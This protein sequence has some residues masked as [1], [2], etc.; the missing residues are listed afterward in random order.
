[1]SVV[2]LHAAWDVFWSS[3]KT[4]PLSTASVS[5]LCHRTCASASLQAIVG[6]RSP[7]NVAPTKYQEVS[8]LVD[9]GSQQTP[10]CSTAVAERLG[11]SGKLNSFALQAGGQPL[12]IYDVGWCELGIN[13][14]S[15]RTYFK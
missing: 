15:C 6:P 12:P 10:L 3:I 5:P 9:S 7:H 11:A 8:I 1:M 2:D 14:R 13:W 4:R